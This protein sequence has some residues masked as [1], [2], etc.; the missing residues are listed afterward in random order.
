MRNAED[1]KGIFILWSLQGLTKSGK[2]PSTWVLMMTKCNLSK[3]SVQAGPLSFVFEG[4]PNFNWA[5]LKLELSC[6]GNLMLS[7]L[8]YMIWTNKYPSF[9]S[10]PVSRKTL[11]IASR[12]AMAYKAWAKSVQMQ[13]YRYFRKQIIS[14]MRTPTAVSMFFTFF[15]IVSNSKMYLAV[16]GSSRLPQ[17]PSLGQATSGATFK[18]RNSLP[19][20][21]NF[22]SFFY[23]E[24]KHSCSI[25]KY[26]SETTY[27]RVYL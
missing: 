8:K 12:A 19:S 17:E 13:S 9:L 4:T 18:Q 11:K 16:A 25:R 23:S 26:F 10:R 22:L 2:N 24:S 6:A 1:W 14:R 15:F 5:N 20:S 7:Y 21:K 27:G 3:N